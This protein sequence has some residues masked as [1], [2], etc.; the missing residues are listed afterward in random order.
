MRIGKPGWGNMILFGKSIHMQYPTPDDPARIQSGT[1]GCI[2]PRRYSQHESTH[3]S[4]YE[5]DFKQLLT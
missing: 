3:L 5:L 1:Q 2:L 4:Q